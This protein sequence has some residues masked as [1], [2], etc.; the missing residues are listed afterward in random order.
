MYPVAVALQKS[1][2]LWFGLLLYYA[3]AETQISM[4]PWRIPCYL[5]HSGFANLSSIFHFG[6]YLSFFFFFL[7][8]Q[9]HLHWKTLYYSSATFGFGSC[10]SGDSRYVFPSTGTN[11]VQLQFSGYNSLIL[12][13]RISCWKKCAALCTDLLCS[14]VQLVVCIKFDHHLLV[15]RLNHKMKI[16]YSLC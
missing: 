3:A 8:P 11:A 2:H 9:S 4:N 16:N 13:D 10:Y 15:P 14:E 7:M 12:R 6:M 5:N 1:P